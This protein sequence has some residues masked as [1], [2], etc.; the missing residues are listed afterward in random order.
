VVEVGEVEDV[1]EEGVDIKGD[2]SE[3]N[4]KLMLIPQQTE[5]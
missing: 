5:R 4:D 3:L 2:A 1:V